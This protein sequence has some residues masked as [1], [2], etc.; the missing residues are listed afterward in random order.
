MAEGQALGPGEDQGSPVTASNETGLES[1]RPP[2][3]QMTFSAPQEIGREGLPVVALPVAE[4]GERQTPWPRGSDL[5][6]H[7]L[8][9]GRGRPGG[10]LWVL[11][12]HEGREAEYG[13]HTHSHT[14]THTHTVIM[15][16]IREESGQGTFRQG[17]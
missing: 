8:C 16:K 11:S 2:S 5:P 3:S 17:E 13:K 12:T 10:G 6:W 1:S 7:G 9:H 15:E 14:H 4:S